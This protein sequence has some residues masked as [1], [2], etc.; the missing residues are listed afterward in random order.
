MSRFSKSIFSGFGLD[1]GGF[2]ASKLEPSWL[3]RPQKTL[4]AALFK[5]LKLSVLKKL[6]LGGLQT[7]F[8]R[9]Q[10]SIWKGLGTIFSRCSRDFGRAFWGPSNQVLHSSGHNFGHGFWHQCV[11]CCMKPTMVFTWAF[12]S[13]LQRSGTCAAHPPPPEGRAVRARQLFT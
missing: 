9:P 10:G 1:F 4:W 7:W 3:L 5:P 6:L 13:F 12:R 8:W 2:W 11:N